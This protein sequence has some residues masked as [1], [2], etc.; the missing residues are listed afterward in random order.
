MMRAV[1]S[2]T[3]A[4]LAGYLA[5]T[6]TLWFA[7]RFSHVHGG[8]LTGFHVR[9][10]H[11]LYPSAGTCLSDAFRYGR[12]WHDSVYAFLPWLALLASAVWWWLP[13]GLAALVT[14]E[15]LAI[16][17]LFSYVHEQ[18]HLAG[19]WLSPHPAFLRARRRHF[20]HH[21]AGVNFAVYDHLWDRAF[22]TFRP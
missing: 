22:G 12:G 3:L 17:G 5:T 20:L 6:F 14:V 2:C 7:H 21:D 8:P 11:A 10:H 19:S 1:A 4:L 16:V 9:G 13:H 18:F 15:A